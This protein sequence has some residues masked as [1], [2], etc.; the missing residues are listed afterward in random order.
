MIDRSLIFASQLSRHALPSHFPC[1]NSIRIVVIMGLTPYLLTDQEIQSF[2][3]SMYDAADALDRAHKEAK[4]KGERFDVD[5][6]LR[7]GLE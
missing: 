2:R 6:Y 5:A 1:G 3:K 7:R 4:E